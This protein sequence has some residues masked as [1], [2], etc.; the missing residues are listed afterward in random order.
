[1]MW[2]E[3]ND[4]CLGWG[5]GIL[6][7][8]ITS[9]F[10]LVGAVFDRE[11]RPDMDIYWLN[12]R[13]GDD[14][15]GGIDGWNSPLAVWDGEGML[16]LTVPTGEGFGAV[17]HERPLGDVSIE[18]TFR[19]IDVPAGSTASIG[20]MCRARE[21]GSGYYFVVASNGQYSIQLARLGEDDLDMLVNWKETDALLPF[22]QRNLINAACVQ[23]YLALYVN[24][25]YVAEVTDRTYSH[26]RVGLTT[27]A[28]GSGGEITA[29]VDAVQVWQAAARR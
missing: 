14:F 19:E 3:R 7:L 9:V 25:R 8:V 17:V 18:A 28:T 10:W 29:N 12:Q 21:E 11:D 23:D 20:V 6:F 22:S 1:M 24:G 26:G 4:G 27:A 2:R 16:N 13:I 15:A 5:L